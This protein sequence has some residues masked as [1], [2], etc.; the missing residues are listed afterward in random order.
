V[1]RIYVAGSSSERV[2]ARSAM[3]LVS[4]SASHSLT[5]DWLEVVE[6]SKPDHELTRDEACKAALADLGGLRYAHTLWFLLPQTPSTGAWFELGYFARRLCEPMDSTDPTSAARR[7]RLVIS[8][9]GNDSIFVAWLRSIG[10][11]RYD[12]DY[13]AALALELMEAL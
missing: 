7:H 5:H 11:E 12:S 13:E 10:A 6:S 3:A 2:R 8:G 9:P 4:Q 1:I